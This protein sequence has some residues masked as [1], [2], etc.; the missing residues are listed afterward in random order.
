[1]YELKMIKAIKEKYV[2][3]DEQ[4]KSPLKEIHMNRNNPH[5]NSGIL[6][7][8]NHPENRPKEMREL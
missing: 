2:R 6:N 8:L 4:Q 7:S 3:A 1:M 5:N